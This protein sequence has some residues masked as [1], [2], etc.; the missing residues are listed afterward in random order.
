MSTSYFA[1]YASL[2]AEVKAFNDQQLHQH[3]TTPQG[4]GW[5]GVDAQTIRFD[6]VVKVLPDDAN[7]LVSLNDV[8]CGYGALLE[9]LTKRGRRVNYRGYE[10]S[11]GML[12]QARGLHGSPMCSFEPLEALSPADYTIASGIFGLSFSHSEVTWHQYVVDTL[13]LFDRNSAKGFSFNMLTS[14]SDEDR[15]RSELHYADPCVIFDLCK[16]KF[17]RNVALYHDY[18]LYD[19]TIVVRKA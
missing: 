8:G 4:V 5:N 14:Y 6:Q 15:K 11:H 7:Q 18:N 2:L 13:E 10:V 3:G 17:S 1:R 12:A 19:F 9:Y 16:R